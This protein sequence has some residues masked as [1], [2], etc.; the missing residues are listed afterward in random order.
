MECHWICNWKWNSIWTPYGTHCKSFYENAK[1]SILVN[2]VTQNPERHPDVHQRNV[3][4]FVY[5]IRNHQFLPEN[6]VTL[7]ME[8][9]QAKSK[10]KFSP[11][12]MNLKH[13]L[14]LSGEPYR[15]YW[16]FDCFSRHLKITVIIIFQGYNVQVCFSLFLFFVCLFVLS[17]CGGVGGV[18]V[19]GV[20]W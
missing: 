1:Q 20:G 7:W 6:I 19:A 4:V 9:V 11:C 17:L 18:W 8:I 2:S 12:H 14:F 16:N 3:F 10:A 5:C 13:S 15:H